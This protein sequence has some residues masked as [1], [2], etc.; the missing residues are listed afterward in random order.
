MPMVFVFI[1][2]ELGAEEE[3]IAALQAIGGVK[4]MAIV[5]GV[6]DIVVKVVAS[7]MDEIKTIIHEQI[8]KV[9]GVQTTLTQVVVESR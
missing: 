5:Y 7:S 9:E 6:Y 4:E 1:N 3:V 8:R 2:S